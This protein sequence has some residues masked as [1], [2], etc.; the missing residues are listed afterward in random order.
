MIDKIYQNTHFNRVVAE[1]MQPQK[2]QNNRDLNYPWLVCAAGEPIF[3]KTF[4][5]MN[6]YFFWFECK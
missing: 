6:K 1:T 3:K 5:A 2:T 4:V